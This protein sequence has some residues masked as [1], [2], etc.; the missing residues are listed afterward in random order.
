MS[1][2]ENYKEVEKRVEEACKRAGR[3]REEVT[4]IAVSKTKPVSMIEE[5]LPLNVR[6]FGENK[7]QELTA[8]AEI[9]PSAL[10]WHMIGHLQRNKVKY[11]VDKACIIHSV[12]SLRLAEEISKAAQKKQVTAKILIEV[13]VAEEESKFGV[14]TSELLPL[15]EAI[16]PLPN[17]AIKGLMTIAPYVE[18]PEE[19]RWIFQK[20][21]NLSIDIK[22]KNF[23]N[24]TMDVLSM[25]MTGDY[26]VAIEE[27]ATHVRVGTGI[28]GERNYT[29]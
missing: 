24:V 11:I 18:N 9:L 3:K 6:D 26:E 29:I 13:N 10:H 8:K 15:I 5:L 28:F 17:I 22:G 16:S 14:R 27:G 19:N 25:G 4:L 21:K 20:L 12:D 1:V 23:D 7:V 2:C